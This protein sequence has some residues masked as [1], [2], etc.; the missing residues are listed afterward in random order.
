MPKIKQNTSALPKDAPIK[1]NAL[2]LA[3]LRQNVGITGEE[4][5]AFDEIA[6]KSRP[7]LARLN[8]SKRVHVALSEWQRDQYKNI[9]MRLSGFSP[10]FS[11]NPSLPLNMVG[12]SSA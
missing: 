5:L 10:L 8:L 9:K 4:V 12:K 3:Q 6:Q 1:Q 11:P 2:E 7:E